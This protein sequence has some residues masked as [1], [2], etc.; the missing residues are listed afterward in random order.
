MTSPTAASSAQPHLPRPARRPTPPV[1][2]EVAFISGVFRERYENPASST[3]DPRARSPRFISRRT[4]TTSSPPPPRAKPA[5]SPASI[6]PHLQV[7]R[8]LRRAEPGGRGLRGVPPSRSPRRRA[9]ASRIPRDT[10]S[11]A[12]KTRTFNSHRIKTRSTRRVLRSREARTRRRRR[13]SPRWRRRPTLLALAAA[14]TE[15]RRA[16]TP[17]RVPT[18][19]PRAGCP[20]CPGCR[21]PRADPQGAG[22]GTRP[23]GHGRARARRCPTAVGG[24]ASAGTQSRAP[25]RTMQHEPM[26]RPGEGRWALWRLTH[27]SSFAGKGVKQDARVAFGPSFTA[28]QTGTTGGV[29]GGRP[30]GRGGREAAQG[31][32]AAVVVSGAEGY[33]RET[34]VQE[35]TRNGGVAIVEEGLSRCPS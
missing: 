9:L 2:L 24:A 17:P 5:R 33:D 26:R 30:V 12:R 6:S 25:D 34:E 20:G 1:R 16:R 29:A 4:S 18:C 15:R 22:L 8:K 14:A 7:G 13:A 23:G 32:G 10:T 27:M 19:R 31:G 11:L 28:R 3:A 35:G 21:M